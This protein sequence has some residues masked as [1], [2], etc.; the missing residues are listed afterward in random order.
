MRRTLQKVFAEW[1]LLL[2]VAHMAGARAFP[3]AWKARQEGLPSLP[4]Y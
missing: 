3:D 2:A 1:K 4:L